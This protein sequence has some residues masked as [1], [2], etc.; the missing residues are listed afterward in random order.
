MKADDLRKSV[1]QTTETGVVTRQLRIASLLWPQ[2]AS[3]CISHG[4]T[5]RR[6]TRAILGNPAVLARGKEPD[7]RHRRAAFHLMN[8]AAHVEIRGCACVL[9]VAHEVVFQT[10]CLRAYGVI[11]KKFA[12]GVRSGYRGEGSS[13]SP[14]LEEW[15]TSV[16]AGRET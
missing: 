13:T 9:R 2:C 8:D 10:R 14:V 4:E 12:R 3:S 1:H 6:G 7:P 15:C 16:L 11:R 5:P